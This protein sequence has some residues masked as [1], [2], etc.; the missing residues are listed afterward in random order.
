V[1]Y[2][3]AMK[4]QIKIHF[5]KLRLLLKPFFLSEYYWKFI[6]KHC[7][8][9]FVR[10]KGNY[11]PF[12]QYVLSGYDSV[13][14]RGSDLGSSNGNVVI[15]GGYLGD[16]AERY[17]KITSGNILIVEPLSIYVDKLKMRFELCERITIMQTA[18]SEESGLKTIY[19]DGNKSSSLIPSKEYEVVNS[20]D[21]AEIVDYFGSEIYALE[22]NIE[23]GEY[24]V[25]PRLIESGRIFS[26]RNLFIEFH[27]VSNDS[28]L[29]KTKIEQELMKTHELKWDF[30]WV[31]THFQIKPETNLTK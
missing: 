30:S 5:L 11:L 25:L 14:F 3:R 22:C 8:T 17:L 6:G 10:I 19:V 27:Q 16:S 29:R 26:V 1:G 28:L 31:W 7:F 13:M 18:A 20:T 2:A 21:I 24:E 23:G 15:L 9:L 4:N 12:L